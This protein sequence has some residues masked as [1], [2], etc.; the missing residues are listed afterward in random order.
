M[1]NTTWLFEVQ[2]H[3][4]KPS[5]FLL[6]IKA[7]KGDAVCKIVALSHQSSLEPWPQASRLL[8]VTTI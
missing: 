6:Y 2:I 5:S 3:A 1:H 8:I 7:S 4:P